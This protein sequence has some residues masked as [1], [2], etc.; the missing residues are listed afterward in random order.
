MTDLAVD[1]PCPRCGVA[2]GTRC[3]SMGHSGYKALT[4]SHGARVRAYLEGKGM[5][6]KAY[7]DLQRMRDGL[8]VWGRDLPSRWSGHGEDYAP[9]A[10]YVVRRSNDTSLWM[11]FAPG[12]ALLTST[13]RTA[14][15]AKS[16]CQEHYDRHGRRGADAQ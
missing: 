7:D 14:A 1:I 10:H 11:A 6:R 3:T 13:A 5:S 12:G 2:A 15:V 16:A 4:R 9:A 8:L